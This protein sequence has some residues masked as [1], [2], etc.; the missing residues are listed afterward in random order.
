MSIGLYNGSKKV[1]IST[2]NIKLILNN[3]MLIMSVSPLFINIKIQT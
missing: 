2:A 1:K 3:I